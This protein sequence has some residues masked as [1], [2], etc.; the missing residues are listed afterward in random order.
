MHSCVPCG[1]FKKKTWIVKVQE[2][3]KTAHW[4]FIWPIYTTWCRTSWLIFIYH[5]CSF[6]AWDGWFWP[7]ACICMICIFSY[8]YR[9][10]ESTATW[11]WWRIWPYSFGR[12]TR[13][14]WDW[15][16][17]LSFLG[18]HALWNRYYIG[19]SGWGW[20]GQEC[21]LHGPCVLQIS[22]SFWWFPAQF[23]CMSVPVLVVSLL[24]LMYTFMHGRMCLGFSQV[25][26]RMDSWT[27]RRH[28]CRNLHRLIYRFGLTLMVEMTMLEVPVLFRSVETPLPWPV[29]KMSSWMKIVFQKTQG[30]PLLAGFKLGQVKMWEDALGTFWSR[31]KASFPQHAVFR[32]KDSAVLNRCIPI[33]IHGDE[34]RGKL[35]R[36]VMA[37]SVQPLLKA[38]S[39]QKGH[40][41]LGRF[42]YGILPGEMYCSGLGG[43]FETMQDAL[44]QDLQDLYQ[45][46]IQAYVVMLRYV[47]HVSACVYTCMLHACHQVQVIMPDG[48]TTTFFT[49]LCGVKGDWPYLRVPE[50]FNMHVMHVCLACTYHACHVKCG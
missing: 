28:W 23:K 7:S 17:D 1:R 2:E 34:G 44:V 43:S 15:S 5:A 13:R 22:L 19:W 33:L 27:V 6:H 4:A 50:A 11:F 8:R 21:C 36:A 12:P 42:L 10:G 32:E 18:S 37:T 35:R 38:K 26:A 16:P 49:V 25:L 39:T 46:G 29:L 24:F 40:S 48:S 41:F 30:Q 14:V 9:F 20:L 31:F 47:C 3:K 45:H